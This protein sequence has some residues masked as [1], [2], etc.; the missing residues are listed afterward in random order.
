MSAGAVR[1]LGLMRECLLGFRRIREGK[2]L[3][4]VM[5]M[6]VAAW[7]LVSMMYGTSGV[8]G[9][10]LALWHYWGFV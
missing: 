7:L 10:G 6:Q 2:L 4:K 8:D 3:K 5:H 9:L 1:N